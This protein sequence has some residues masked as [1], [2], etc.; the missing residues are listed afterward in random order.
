[1]LRK[2]NLN[3]ADRIL[4]VLTPDFGKI[5]VMAKGV[6][7]LKSRFCGRLETLYHVELSCFRG[8]TLS[9]LNEAELISADPLYE[10]DLDQHRILFAIAEITDRLVPEADHAA[11]VYSLLLDTLAH[12]GKTDKPENLF[13]AFLIKLLTILGFMAPWDYCARSRRKLTAAEP[14][15]LNPVEGCIV[16]AG[17]AGALDIR[18]CAPMVKWVNFMQRYAFEDIL[19]VT[20][21][22]GER[23]QVWYMLTGMLSNL[24]SGQLKSDVFLSKARL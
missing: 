22:P 24:L 14:L 7:R 13:H 4:T 15:Y 21:T 10:L 9:H 17:Y 3:E 23:Q 8:N 20:T 11:E 6:R 2:V 1:M 16:C 5:S 19:R 12:L 18:I